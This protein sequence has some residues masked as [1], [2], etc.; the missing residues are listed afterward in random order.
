VYATLAAVSGGY[1]QR[2]PVKLGDVKLGPGDLSHSS[3][4]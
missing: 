2:Q 4:G 1:Q 3:V